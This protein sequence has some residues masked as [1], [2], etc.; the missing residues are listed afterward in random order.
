MQIHHIAIW[1][2]DLERLKSF[3]QKYFLFSA[4]EKYVNQK[5]GF[6]S[7]FL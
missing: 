6:Q 7:Y 1:T 5:T 2:N 3:Y 4:S